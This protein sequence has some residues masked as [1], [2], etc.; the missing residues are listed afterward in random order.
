MCGTE[1][2]RGMNDMAV[3]ERFGSAVRNRSRRKPTSFPAL[4]NETFDRHEREGRRL[5]LRG[6]VA[7][8][9]AIYILVA[10]IAPYPESFYYQSLVIVFLLTG[11]IPAAIDRLGWLRN[12][13][14]Y[15]FVTLDFALMTVMMLYPNPFSPTDYPPQLA[16]RFETF[17]YF[18]VLIAGLAFSDQPRLVLWG[19]FVGIVSW[20][21]GLTWLASLPDSVI[22]S[23]F[24]PGSSSLDL[25]ERIAL[26][27]N[28]TLIDLSVEAQSIV[29]LGIVAMILA[30][31]VARSRRLVWR[32]AAIERQ[33]LNLA[34]YFPP[35]TVDEL[36]RDDV[37]L[38]EIRE[39][40]AAILFADVVG[41]TRWSER[42]S[43][44]E[45][46]SLLREVHGLLEEAIFRHGGTLDKFI[47]DGI[48]ATFGTPEPLPQDPFNAVACVNAILE[49]VA[50][51]NERRVA[52]GAEPVQI[53]VG[54]HYGPVVVGNIGTE[55]RLELAV[56][57]DTVN[58]ASRLEELT[59]VVGRA[60]AV[61]DDVVADIRAR[62]PNAA[63]RLMAGFDFLGDNHLEGR[64]QG[65]AVWASQ[66]SLT[67]HES[68]RPKRPLRP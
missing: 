46:I 37:S 17:G 1:D 18:F 21:V 49:D 54:L 22:Y 16:L 5:Q 6:R 48:M 66:V 29:V 20:V 42:H 40:N 63:D 38:A 31:G 56:I 24:A 43:P 30:G 32:H 59:R 45:T 25:S 53:A 3:A 15:V 61:S 9:V 23:P 60:A 65:I 36:A 10:V 28:P 33:R 52:R 51:L 50:A 68:R 55:R 12:W 14:L 8:L 41:F 57:G 26:I 11:F 67:A 44:V 39:L 34:R 27:A 58:A 7:A 62:D 19:G 2:S 4:L 35:A 13:H 47:G 64:R